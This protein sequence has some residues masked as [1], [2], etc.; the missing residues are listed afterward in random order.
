[1]VLLSGLWPRS[2][3]KVPQESHQESQSMKLIPL[4]QGKV[5]KVSDRDYAFLRQWKWCHRK[6][7]NGNEG[8]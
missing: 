2:I 4:T 1:V 6:C 8:H 5:A 7:N 3:A